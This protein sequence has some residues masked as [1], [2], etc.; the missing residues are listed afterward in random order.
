MYKA[1]LKT[2]IAPVMLLAFVGGV[3]SSP[4]GLDSRT[5]ESSKGV[6]MIKGVRT[7][8]YH[9]PDIEKATQWY[10][11]ILGI[12]PY[13]KEP[14][15]V[16]FNVGGFE[17]GLDPDMK[18]ITVGGNQIAYWGVENADAALKYL[19]DHGAKEHSAVKVV[20][21]GPKGALK[22]A[23]VLDPFGNE[24]GVIENPYFKLEDVR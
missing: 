17:L 13:F 11:E 1:K 21:D 3:H 23:I 2:I 5:K 16:G 15:Y 20:G 9:V 12:E 4:R 24:F 10:S 22:V 6:T 14:Y 19:L 8:I 18:G 7:I